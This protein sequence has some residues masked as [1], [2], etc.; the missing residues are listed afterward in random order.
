METKAFLNSQMQAS[1][2]IYSFIQLFDLN[3]ASM[4]LQPKAGSIALDS[5]QRKITNREG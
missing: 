3:I 5:V 4:S 2:L 1:Y